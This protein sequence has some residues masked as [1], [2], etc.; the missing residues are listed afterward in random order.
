MKAKRSRK[1]VGTNLLTVLMKICEKKTAEYHANIVVALWKS[2]SSK[3]FHVFYILKF[4]TL[5]K[6]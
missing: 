6:E 1:I 4:H 5:V 2:N 3:I